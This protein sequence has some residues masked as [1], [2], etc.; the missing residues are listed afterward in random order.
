MVQSFS[1][2]LL[3]H[4]SP[5]G[6]PV[7]PANLL[8]HGL[9]SPWI[10]RSWKELDPVR[11]S[12]GITASFRDPLAPA[13]GPPWWQVDICSTMDLHGLQGDSFPHHCLLHGCRGMS[14]PAP[15]APPP[16]PSSLTLLSAELFLSDILTL[17]S[18]LPFHHR[19]F[20]FLNMLS[21]KRYQSRSWWQ[22]KW[23]VFFWKCW[24]LTCSS[25]GHKL[26][27]YYFWA[28]SLKSTVRNIDSSEAV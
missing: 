10:H 14:D 16:P 18:Q 8:Q 27:E 7:L 2:R 24:Q 17:L 4:G 9:L 20:P 6:S 1:N 19:F 26:R 12:H 5:T 15:G 25:K 11:V 3:Q 21:Q 23:S 28:W 13:R 22:W